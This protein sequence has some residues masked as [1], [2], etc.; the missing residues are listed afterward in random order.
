[1]EDGPARRTRSATNIQGEKEDFSSIIESEIEV[2]K[3]PV[4]SPSVTRRNSKRKNRTPSGQQLSNSVED[5]RNFF[6]QNVEHISGDRSPLTKNKSTV[7][8]AKSQWTAL[9]KCSQTGQ[10]TLIQAFSAHNLSGNS[11]LT[12]HS[13]T[14]S[15]SESFLD[16]CEKVNNTKSAIKTNVRNS[17]E[18]IISEKDQSL[19][20]EK[21]L[22]YQVINTT[23][24]MASAAVAINTPFSIV[25]RYEIAKNIQDQRTEE[26]IYLEK[27][28]AVMKSLTENSCTEQVLKESLKQNP[29]FEAEPENEEN[30]VMD[31]KVIFQMFQT[32]RSD[33]QRNAIIGGENRMAEIEKRQDE[34][35]EKLYVMESKMLECQTKNE[36]LMGAVKQLSTRI[37]DAESR[38]ERIEWNN[39]KNSIVATGF[40][41]NRKK[42]LCI[43]EMEAFFNGEME[44]DVEI[45]DIFFLSPDTTPPMVIVF[46]NQQY[47]SQVFRNIE[48]IK[49]LVNEYDSS[50]FFNDYLPSEM[51]E[52]KR[53]E[54]D[55]FRFNERQEDKDKFAMQRKAG[56]LQFENNQ[57]VKKIASPTP[58]D[59]VSMTMDDLDRIMKI[60]LKAGPEIKVADNTFIAY[61]TIT[62]EYS[63][64]QDSYYKMKLLHPSSKHILC[65]YRIPG[66]RTFECEDYCDDKEHGSGRVILNWMREH[67]ITG[68][69][70][71]LVRYYKTRIGNARYENYIK[72][73]E[74]LFKSEGIPINR[75]DETTSNRKIP[76]RK[77]T[78]TTSTAKKEEEDGFC[79]S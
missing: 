44:I 28:K 66:T 54:N 6:Q 38:I 45:D 29:I 7:K 8:N 75:K 42:N 79:S 60:E 23:D 35:K 53:R 62:K 37:E 14:I 65:I 46:K 61:T 17:T 31:V 18:V 51:S 47:K 55:I 15:R 11:Q 12:D 71:F 64:I 43:P 20:K 3:T 56:K 26:S 74:E 10:R 70:I 36:L 52:R 69:A 50:F 73:T 2:F 27:R 49:D 22:R 25:D 30:Q 5:I 41:C 21:D 78:T 19:Q 68:R 63:V 16:K 33:I 24:T 59:L 32:L 58:K 57:Y 48:K 9:E 67:D 76:S 13:R 4:N 40:Y 77:A 34:T 1:M 39:M 72:A